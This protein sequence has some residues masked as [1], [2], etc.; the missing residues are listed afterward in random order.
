M[1]SGRAEGGTHEL[2]APPWQRVETT[3]MA[4]ARL[5]REAGFEPMERDNLY[6][7]YEVEAPT[8]A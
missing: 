1:Q 5:I 8:L 4:T 6:R 2:D 7:E 3:L